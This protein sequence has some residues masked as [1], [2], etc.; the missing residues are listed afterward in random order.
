LKNGNSPK[1]NRKK[2]KTT[3]G[4]TAHRLQIKQ[5][6]SPPPIEF[7]AKERHQ[8]TTNG[9][10]VSISING[11]L[12]NE[13]KKWKCVRTEHGRALRISCQDREKKVGLNERGGE[14]GDSRHQAI[15]QY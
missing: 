6:K 13:K 3:K 7:T 1:E 9:V 11:H 14:G 10:S 5:E 4:K 2:A 8:N 12:I 15:A